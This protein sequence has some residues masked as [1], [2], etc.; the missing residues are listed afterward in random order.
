MANT[1]PAPKPV[2]AETQSASAAVEAA[3]ES[4]GKGET[5]VQVMY[6]TSKFVTEYGVID[7]TGTK[8][9]KANADKIAVLAKASKVKV[10]ID[11]EVAR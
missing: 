6:P 3:P 11:G 2:V 4:S 1:T 5:L 9:S 7:Q 8:V 10:L